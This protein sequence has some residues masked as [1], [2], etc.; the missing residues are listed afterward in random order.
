MPPMTRTQ[1]PFGSRRSITTPMRTPATVDGKPP[2]N[3]T[4]TQ[5]R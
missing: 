3:V 1:V 4:V 5:C 2:G